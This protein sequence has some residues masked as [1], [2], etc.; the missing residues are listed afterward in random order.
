[1]ITEIFRLPRQVSLPVNLA[2]SFPV[3]LPPF[4]GGKRRAREKTIKIIL[5]ANIGRAVIFYHLPIKM[6]PSE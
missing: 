6:K 4:F 3:N 5:K 2:R 1:L